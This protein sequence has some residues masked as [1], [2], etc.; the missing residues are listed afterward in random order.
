MLL[1]VLQGFCVLIG[2]GR[3]VDM[4]DWPYLIFRVDIPV[5]LVCTVLTV[6]SDNSE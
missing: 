4:T 6:T 1:W 5:E 3:N 2:Q